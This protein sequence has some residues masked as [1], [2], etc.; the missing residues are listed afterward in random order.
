MTLSASEW[1]KRRP[2]GLICVFLPWLY[3]TRDGLE[4]FMGWP[5]NL[6][7]S[8]LISNE[9]TTAFVMRREVL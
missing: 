6:D 4:P 1:V 9:M 3:L 2:L 5:S 7:Q 8:S